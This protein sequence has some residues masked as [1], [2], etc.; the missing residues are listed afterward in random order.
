MAKYNLLEEPW[1]PILKDAHVMELSLSECLLRSPAIERIETSSPLEEAVLHRLLLAILHRA[2]DGPKD[3]DE[4]LDWLEAGSF[5]TAPIEAYLEQYHDRFFL[6]HEIAPFFQVPDLPEDKSREPWVS[7]RFELA[8]GNNP[9]L[10]DHTTEED[11]PLATYAEVARSLLVRQAYHPGG[12]SCGSKKNL[13]SG[14]LADAAALLPLGK[15]LFETLV[16][17]LPPYDAGGDEP[18]W[19]AEPL[20]SAKLE[21]YTLTRPFSGVCRVYT[22]LTAG[23][24]LLDDGDRV[25]NVSWGPGVKRLPVSFRDP[26]VGYRLGRA[27]DWERIGLKEERSFW[28]D[29]TAMLPARQDE[30]PATLTHSSTVARDVNTSCNLRVIGRVRGR[31]QAKI[32][33]VRREVYPLP[34]DLL[35]AAAQADL[36]QALTK[37]EEVGQGLEKAG[38]RLARDVLGETD[39]EKKMDP[40]HLK[41]LRAFVNSLPLLR[42]FWAD[43]D[44]A[45]PHFLERLGQPEALVNWRLALRRAAW[46][47]WG[48]T[49]DSLGHAGRHLKGIAR[50]E[51]E[52]WTSL[53]ALGLREV[54]EVRQ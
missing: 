48:T 36:Q 37:A 29:F 49:R 5:P 6:F 18:I 9:T 38:C 3:L 35:S 51:R 24:R 7:L 22:W 14:P 1:I 45:F 4:A 21:G 43:L 11:F 53:N 23:V 52:L 40:K 12:R 31:Q 33:D 17:N 42:L 27:G 46:Q 50:G 44:A 13:E 16:L 30:W 19:E 8:S 34:G 39:P 28:R 10:F 20:R 25:R 41:K 47:A 54:E 32:L 2:L 15:S 26:M